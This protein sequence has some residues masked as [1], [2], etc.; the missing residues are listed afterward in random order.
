MGKVVSMRGEMTPGDVLEEARG[1]EGVAQVVV[2]LV[3]G[4]DGE[5][6]YMHSELDNPLEVAGFMDWVKGEI[7][8]GE[9]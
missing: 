9:E 3:K 1:A 5:W 8:R 4:S 7:V 2:L 6:D